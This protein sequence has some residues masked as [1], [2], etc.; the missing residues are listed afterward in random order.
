MEK[1]WLILLQFCPNIAESV[2]RY[3]FKFFVC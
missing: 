2:S 1:R 3:A